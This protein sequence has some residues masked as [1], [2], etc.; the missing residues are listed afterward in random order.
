MV[1]PF[2]VIALHLPTLFRICRVCESVFN[3]R[4]A[5]ANQHQDIVYGMS[6]NGD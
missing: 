6:R 3:G 4:S 5:K 1:E 2:F